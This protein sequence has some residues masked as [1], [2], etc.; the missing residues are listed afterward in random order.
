[1]DIPVSVRD[2]HLVI[3]L[4]SILESESNEEILVDVVL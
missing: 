3:E 2:C 4:V 1:M